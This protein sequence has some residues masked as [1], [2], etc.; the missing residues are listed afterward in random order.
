MSPADQRVM[1]VPLP[2]TLIREMDSVILDGLGGYATRAE[3]IVDAIQ[4][5]ILELSVGVIED[6][7]PHRGRLN[8]RREE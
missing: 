7:A 1:R 3:F 5:R 2:V 8:R 6:A 4:E